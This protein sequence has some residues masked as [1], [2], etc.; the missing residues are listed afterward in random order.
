[1]AF[2]EAVCFEEMLCETLDEKI[3]ANL[4]RFTVE[5]HI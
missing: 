1:M 4:Q 2:P 3:D 5:V